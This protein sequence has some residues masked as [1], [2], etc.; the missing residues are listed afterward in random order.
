MQIVSVNTSSPAI[1]VDLDDAAYV[2]VDVAALFP[3]VLFTKRALPH[4]PC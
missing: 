2:V 3:R 4:R 1:R